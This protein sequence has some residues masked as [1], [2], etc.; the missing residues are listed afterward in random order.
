MT[1]EDI[2]RGLEYVVEPD[3]KKNIVEAGLV[4]NIK[5]EGNKVSFDLAVSNPAMHN[6]KRITDACDHYLQMHVNKEIETDISVSALSS[7]PNEREDSQRKY[8]SEVKHVIAVASGKGGVGKSTITANLAAGLAKQGYKV[9]LIDADIYGPSMPMMF[10]TVHEKPGVKDFGDKRMI[11]PVESP[12]GV[13]II[14]IGYF[15]DPEQA[16]VWRGP[17]ATKALQQMFR[18]VYWGELDFML[19]DLPPGTGDVHLTLVKEAPLTGAIVVST[20]QDVALADAKKGVSMFQ[21]KEI[22]VP[23]LGIVENMSYFMPE[24][25]P[26]KKYYIF[27]KDGAKNLA[28]DLKVTLLGQIP[29]VQSVREAGDAGRPAVLQANTPQA[30]AF[31]DLTKKVV[32]VVTRK[33]QPE[34]NLN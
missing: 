19:I 31:E 23:V 17:M 26:D 33:K 3:L 2:I 4:S 8:L 18:D 34:M 16:V 11:T 28:E 32:D 6:R 20:P 9:G 21:L 30:K 13:K 29:L 25:M 24:D 15:A 27:G 1:K 5:I 10:D 22:N 7:D 12:W 14:S